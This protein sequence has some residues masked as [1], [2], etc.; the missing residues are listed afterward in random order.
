M[1]LID[2]IFIAILMLILVGGFYCMDYVTKFK[3]V[4]VVKIIRGIS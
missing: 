4:Q 1:K 2:Y 3:V